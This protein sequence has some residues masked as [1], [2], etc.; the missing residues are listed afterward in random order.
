VLDALPAVLARWKESVLGQPA[1][2]T[3]VT[4]LGGGKSIGRYFTRTYSRVSLPISAALDDETRALKAALLSSPARRPLSLDAALAVVSAEQGSYP[5]V[6]GTMSEIYLE[7]L[8]TRMMLLSDKSVGL[9]PLGPLPMEPVLQD[10]RSHVIARI[11]LDPQWV[12]HECFVV[13]LE[14]GSE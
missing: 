5:H 3:N 7:P 11:D 2:A 13:D 12:G 6:G 10:L 14:S 4:G 8:L 1:T 9:I